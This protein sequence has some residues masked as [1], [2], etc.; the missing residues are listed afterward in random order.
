[1]PRMRI[2]ERGKTTRGGAGFCQGTE[3]M[4]ERQA[5][6]HPLFDPASL[7]SR[8]R[9]SVRAEDKM[10]GYFHWLAARAERLGARLPPSPPCSAE[11]LRDFAAR[12]Q[13][14]DGRGPALKVLDSVELRAWCIPTE[15]SDTRQPTL[16]QAVLRIV[17]EPDGTW[18]VILFGNHVLLEGGRLDDSRQ[19]D[20]GRPC[21]AFLGEPEVAMRLSIALGSPADTTT[22]SPLPRVCM[23]EVLANNL[24]VARLLSAL[25]EL[26]GEIHLESQEA[27]FRRL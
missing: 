26:E 14:T 24:E 8:M 12:L 15:T 19:Q 22:E 13:T 20:A 9:A 25:P 5:P 18:T 4:N 23:R 21:R 6:K 17:G 11:K 16:L 10:R 7:S 3:S 2:V 27:Q 1:M